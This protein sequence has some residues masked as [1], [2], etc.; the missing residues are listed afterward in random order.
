MLL[1]EF[2]KEAREGKDEIDPKI[3]GSPFLSDE[4]QPGEVIT[5]RG[6]FNPVNMRYNIQQDA[7]EF[8]L[9]GKNL[10]M[11]STALIKSIT[12]N[13][14]KFVVGDYPFQSRKVRGFL[15]ELVASDVALYAKKNLSFRDAMA[16][17]PLE[18]EPTPAKYVKLSDTHYLNRPN[19]E[20][21]KVNGSKDIIALLPKKSDSLKKFAKKEK[22]SNKCVEDMKRLVEFANTIQ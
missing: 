21:I 9:G 3:E 1:K 7:M 13:N 11:D 12:L 22:L 2:D 16:P 17:K 14:E 10:Y 5:M 6:T 20:L 4:F 18:S 15:V 19:E 8:N